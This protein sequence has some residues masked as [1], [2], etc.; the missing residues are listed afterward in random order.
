M[1]GAPAVLPHVRSGRRRAQRLAT[2]P[3]VP[4]MAESGYPD[5]EADQWYGLVA[6]TG[7]PAAWAARVNAEVRPE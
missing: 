1:P 7:L 2:L 3:E 5:F 4:T 6:P